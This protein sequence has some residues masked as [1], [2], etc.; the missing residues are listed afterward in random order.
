[1]TLPVIDFTAHPMPRGPWIRGAPVTIEEHPTPDAGW[2]LYSLP[3]GSVVVV[4]PAPE[5]MASWSLV[6]LSLWRTVANL[7]RLCPACGARPQLGAAIVRGQ[8]VDAVMV[9]ENRCILSDGM[10]E[11]SYEQ[12]AAGGPLPA[13][14]PAAPRQWIVAPPRLAI[15]KRRRRR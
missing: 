9:H 10:I 8:P 2:S 15:R 6:L 4:S 11:A 13:G 12:L 7:T 14:V 1:M 5:R 3:G